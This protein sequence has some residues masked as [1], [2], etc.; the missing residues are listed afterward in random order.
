MCKLYCKMSSIQLQPISK[1]LVMTMYIFAYIYV[2][3]K[4]CQRVKFKFYHVGL[5]LV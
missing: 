4:L 5:M 1:T 2:A 3:F